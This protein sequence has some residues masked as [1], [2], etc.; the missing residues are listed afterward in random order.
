MSDDVD[1]PLG[2]EEGD[3]ESMSDEDEDNSLPH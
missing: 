3:D 1:E 2:D